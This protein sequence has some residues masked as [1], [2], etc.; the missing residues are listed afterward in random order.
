MLMSILKT[1]MNLLRKILPQ[2]GYFLYNILLYNIFRNK[3]FVVFK[4]L[5]NIVSINLTINLFVD[6]N[7]NPP[8]EL[9]YYSRLYSARSLNVYWINV[10]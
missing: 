2:Q 5:I 1:A 3:F 9:R 6:F 4:M 10:V 7:S 8:L